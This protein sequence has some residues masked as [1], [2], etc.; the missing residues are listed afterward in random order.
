MPDYK[1][2]YLTLFNRV[3]DVI[4]ELQRAQRETER[5]YINGPELDAVLRD[6]NSAAA[7]AAGGLKKRKRPPE[8]R[9]SIRRKRRESGKLRAAWKAGEGRKR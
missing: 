6:V 3:T 8:K 4:L 7:D 5:L 9:G 1:T 2:M